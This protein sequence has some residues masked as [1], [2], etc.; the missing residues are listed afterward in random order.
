MPGIYKS[1]VEEA[2]ENFKNSDGEPPTMQIEK[3][4]LNGTITLEF[5]HKMLVPADTKFLTEIYPDII[6]VSL[7]SDDGE[8]IVGDFES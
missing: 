4:D 2:M 6:E 7:L 5:S 8:V 1:Q 3:I